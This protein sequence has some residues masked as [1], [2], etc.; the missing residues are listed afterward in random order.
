MRSIW[1]IGQREYRRYFSTPAAYLIMF[2][3]LL[4]M[5]FIFYLNLGFAS[6]SQTAPDM[7]DVFGILIFLLV[8]TTP[9]ITM[10]LLSE[11][12]RMGTI[13][14]LLTAPVRDWEL[15]VGK[16]L[17][18]FLFLLTVLLLTLIYPITLNFLVNPGIDQLLLLSGYLGLILFC[19]ALVGIGVTISAFFSNQVAAFF[20]TIAVFLLLWI[21]GAFAQISPTG[22][23]L[24]SY[25]DIRSHYT[26][27][28]LVGIIDIRD[29]VYYVSLTV[30]SLFLGSVFTEAR[31]WQ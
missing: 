24:I 31:R 25:L 23:E 26:E 13:E 17:G 30:L 4:I 15:V 8:I 14:L 16:W 1:I 2:F 21:I 6:Q 28:F 27:T 9:A 18:G 7:R 19:A 10:N 11:E 20:L 22:N 29:I 12:L 5:G 3:L